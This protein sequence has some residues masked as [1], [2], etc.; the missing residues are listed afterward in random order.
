MHFL[1]LAVSH[2]VLMYIEKAFIP[3]AQGALSHGALRII[4]PALGFAASRLLD[5]LA[6]TAAST[7]LRN[8]RRFCRALVQVRAFD[9]FEAGRYCMHKITDITENEGR[10]KTWFQTFTML[11]FFGQMLL[12]VEAEL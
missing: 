10:A 4:R 8:G 9:G 6:C 2:D 7:V 5:A 1:G 11:S 12:W 3:V